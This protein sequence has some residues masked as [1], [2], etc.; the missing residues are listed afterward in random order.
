MGGIVHRAR[1]RVLAQNVFAIVC[2]LKTLLHIHC[3]QLHQKFTLTVYCANFNLLYMGLIMN[4]FLFFSDRFGKFLLG[5]FFLAVSFLA[6]AIGAISYQWNPEH[7]FNRSPGPYIDSAKHFIIEFQKSHARLPEIEEFKAWNIEHIPN[8]D[9][10]EYHKSDF[11]DDLIKL[12]GKPPQDAY[13]FNVWDD[14]TLY[15]ASWYENGTV[16]LITDNDYYWGGSRIMHCIITLGLF[17][18]FGVVASFFYTLAF[19]KSPN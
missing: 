9:G 18:F 12:A 11:P 14:V 6:L 1:V 7:T 2:N 17:L 4:G 8:S 19:E 15:Y 16:G 10:I 3:T 13:Y 5:T